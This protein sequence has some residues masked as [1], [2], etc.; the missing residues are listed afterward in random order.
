MWQVGVIIAGLA[1]PVLV[2]WLVRDSAVKFSTV[3]AYDTG[4][5]KIFAT[6]DFIPPMSAPSGAQAGVGAHVVV[7]AG[8]SKPT[9]IYLKTYTPQ[10]HEVFERTGEITE[11]VVAG[12]MVRRP[13]D[14]DWVPLNTP[15]GRTIVERTKELAGDRSWQVAIP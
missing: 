12:T 14:Q 9:V 6:H 10:A 13:Q 2:W 4:T 5:G 3:Y 11:D 8:D 7:F 1:L 15:A